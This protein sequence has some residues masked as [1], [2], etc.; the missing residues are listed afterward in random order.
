MF[1]IL[2]RWLME[3][4]GKPYMSTTLSYNRKTGALGIN[5]T[6]NQQFIMALDFNY[7]EAGNREYNPM[8]P[9]NV[10]LAFYLYDA[11]DGIMAQHEN[12]VMRDTLRH[13]G[14]D[15]GD[16]DPFAGVPNLRGN[17]IRDVIDISKMQR[18]SGKID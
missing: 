9:D 16:G 2:K 17:G 4:L 1:K 15:D 3:L 11:F 10:K 7:N 13:D 6:Y 8:L 18:A 5:A 14:D 12:V